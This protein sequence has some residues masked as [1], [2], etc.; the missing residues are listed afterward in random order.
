MLRRSPQRRQALERYGAA[1]GE[2]FQVADDLLDIEGDTEL[3][4]KQTGKDAAAGKATF[5]S[6]LGIPGAKARLKQLVAEAETA[7][8]P[9]GQAASILIEGAHFVAERRA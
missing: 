1:V 9:F 4:G 6:M 3:V 5:V 8:A 7:L 2:A